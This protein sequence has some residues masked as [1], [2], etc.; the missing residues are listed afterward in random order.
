MY[1]VCSLQLHKCKYK[2]KLFFYYFS[3]FHRQKLQFS[4]ELRLLIFYARITTMYFS[5]GAPLIYHISIF[6][7]IIIPDETDQSTYKEYC[8]YVKYKIYNIL[9]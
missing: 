2:G 3:R 8:T 4:F 9:Y 5:L 7:Y 6:F 1:N